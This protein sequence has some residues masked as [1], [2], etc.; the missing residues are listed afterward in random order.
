[1][2]FM[3]ELT[4]M[5]ILGSEEMH[6]NTSVFSKI[7]MHKHIKLKILSSAAADSKNINSQW[8]ADIDAILEYTKEIMREK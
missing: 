4:N 1:M 8:T 5:L 2:L 3:N 6:Q 7:A